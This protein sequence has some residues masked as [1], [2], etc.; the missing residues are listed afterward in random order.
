MI[1]L[2]PIIYPKFYTCHDASKNELVFLDIGESKILNIDVLDKTQCEALVNHY[3]LFEK[4]GERNYEKIIEIGRAIA[5]NLY[6][7]LL[8]SFPSKLFV[9]Y[10]EVSTK[11]STILRF[12][13]IWEGELPY[14]DMTQIYD[15]VEIFEI[16]GY[17]R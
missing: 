14:F 13:Q 4:M 9:I 8:R 12:H 7:S 10:L 11:N 1:D 2:M 6:D 5:N 15:D 16:G 3:H 17:N